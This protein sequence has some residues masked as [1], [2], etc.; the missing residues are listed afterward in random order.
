MSKIVKVSVVIFVV[1]LEGCGLSIIKIIDVISVV[2]LII[3]V[4]IGK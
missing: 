3:I 1:S 2:I 4:K